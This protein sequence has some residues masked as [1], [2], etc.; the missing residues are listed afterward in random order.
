M[1]REQFGQP[2]DHV[3]N[4]MWW[5][6]V[7][8]IERLSVLQ[9]VPMCCKSGT[10]QATSAV[11]DSAECLYELRLVTQQASQSV[12]V[13]CHQVGQT[14]QSDHS[15]TAIEHLLEA[16]L[17]W[18]ADPTKH[19][20]EQCNRVG[21]VFCP[22]GSTSVSLDGARGTSMPLFAIGARLLHHTSCSLPPSHASSQLT[23]LPRRVTD[24]EHDGKH[25]LLGCYRLVDP[26]ENVAHISLRVVRVQ[27]DGPRLAAGP[28]PRERHD[29]SSHVRGPPHG[30]DG[31]LA[32]PQ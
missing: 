25:I 4:C 27:L 6:K 8:G 15:W 26:G 28:A 10:E 5:R 19:T 13:E 7:R 24:A 17:Q 29:E 18:T 22:R 21:C 20:V 14:K 12:E 9:L 23:Q 2:S 11:V 30:C 32:V 16:E 1:D 3:H 31:L